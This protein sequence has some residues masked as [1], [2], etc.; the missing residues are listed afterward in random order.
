MS[1]TITADSIAAAV[2]AL[3]SKL[4]VSPEDRIWTVDELIR[5]RA[6]ELEDA[7]LI[8]YPNTGLLGFEEHSARSVDRYADAAAEKLQSL[9]LTPVVSIAR[10]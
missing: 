5:R 9:G 7:P 1:S 6:S 4:S 10:A 3:P 8:A 2:E